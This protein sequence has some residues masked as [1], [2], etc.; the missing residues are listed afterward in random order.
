M[1]FREKVKA[2]LADLTEGVI[3]LDEL[4]PLRFEDLR[5][6]IVVLHATW[7]GP[8]VKV[9]VEYVKV[10]H[11]VR[12]SIVFPIDFYILNFDKISIDFIKRLPGVFGGNGET[13]FVKNGAVIQN[14][15]HYD[16]SFESMLL[17]CYGP[18]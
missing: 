7:S 14:I 16:E 2:L 17:R 11:E 1:E 5:G 12:G 8:S 4:D 10:F 9:L 18:I 15:P 13:F 6:A 3:I